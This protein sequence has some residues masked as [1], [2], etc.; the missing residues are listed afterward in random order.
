MLRFYRDAVARSP[1]SSPCSPALV[2]APDGS[3]HEA[4]GDGRLPH[5]DPAEAE[6]DLAPFKTLGLAADGRGRPDALPGHEHPPR[7]RLPAGSLNYWLSSFTSGLPDELIDT[8][9]RALRVGPLA[10]D[11]D[12]L[13]A[14][15]RRRHPGRRRPTRPSRT[16]RRAG[17]CSSRRSGSTRPTPTANIAW[18]NDTLAAVAQ[19]LAERPLAQLPRRRPGR[20]RDPGRLRP[21]LRPARSRSSAATTRRTSSTST[22]TS[23]RRPA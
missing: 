9:D 13:R 5:R 2:H 22:T 4:R 17:T 6:R 10:D 20:R 23:H 12:P 11:R 16:A 7:R 1:T 14:L 15:P 19:H 21:E 18:T 8:A 3:G